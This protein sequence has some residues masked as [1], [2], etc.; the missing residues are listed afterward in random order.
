M[1]A[2]TYF[3]SMDMKTAAQNS[4]YIIVFSQ[5]TGIAELLAVGAVPTVSGVL[6]LGMALC[7]LLGSE[8]GHR[9][10]RHLS[11]EDVGRLF[12]GLMVVIMGISVY[13][14]VLHF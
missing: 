5:A 11:Q 4:L 8:A 6:L 12:Q 7:G 13:N 14:M 10:N 2:L 9:V 3:F 1:A